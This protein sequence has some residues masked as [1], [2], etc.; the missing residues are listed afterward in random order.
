M[1]EVMSDNFTILKRYY[2]FQGEPVGEPIDVISR[3]KLTDW[4][5]ARGYTPGEATEALEKADDEGI[6]EII[7]PR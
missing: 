6:V 1:E 5:I 4:L 3:D 2:V 7:V